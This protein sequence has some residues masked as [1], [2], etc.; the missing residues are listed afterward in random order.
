MFLDTPEGAWVAL[1]NPEM[2]ED[3]QGVIV[4]EE[5]KSGKNK[6]N[7]NKIKKDLPHYLLYFLLGCECNHIFLLTNRIIRVNPDL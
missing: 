3:R 1:I 7:N 5:K 6:N 2:D 4:L